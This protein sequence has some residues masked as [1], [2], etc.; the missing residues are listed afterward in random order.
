MSENNAGNNWKPKWQK[1]LDTYYPIYN[2]FIFTGYIDDLLPLEQDGQVVYVTME[3]YI[4]KQYGG[5]EPK[6]CVIVYDP[7]ESVEKQFRICAEQLAQPESD[8]EENADGEEEQ[9]VE[10]GYDDDRAQHF[11]DITHSDDIRDWLIDH[12]NDGP[13]LALS[14]MHYALTE[15]GPRISETER[16]RLPM[17]IKN[18]LLSLLGQQKAGGYI[19]V[20]KMAS[21]LLTRDTVSGNGNGISDEE[22]IIFRQL[23]N[24][25]Q[26]IQ[27]S[28]A[29]KIILLANKKE[30]LPVWFTD[31]IANHYLKIIDVE[32][33]SE[34]LRKYF[35]EEKLIGEG[36]FSDGFMQLYN[37]GTDDYRKRVKKKYVAYTDDFTMGMHVKFG[38]YAQTIKQNGGFAEFDDP[39]KIGFAVT[40]F[41]AGQM[42]N[43]WNDP[44]TVLKLI[45]IKE[46]I[47][48]DGIIG[49]SQALDQAQRI[50]TTAAVGLGR[51][52]SDAPRAVLFLVGPTGTGKTE[53][54]KKIAESVFGSKERM[55]RFD[56][57]EYREAESDQKLFGAP[58]GYVGY[59]N[60][61]R[62]TNA[63]K[64][65][66][67]SL[68]LF[69]E[70][71]KAHPSI[72][73]K[74]L[75]I[76][77]DGRLTDGKGETVRFTDCIIVVTSNCGITIDKEI[78]QE[79][80]ATQMGDEKKNF[81]PEFAEFADPEPVANAPRVYYHKIITIADIIAKEQDGVDRNI[82]YNNLK[83][84]LRF[85]VKAYFYCKLG[86]PELYGRFS[87]AMVY[88][89]FISME[90]VRPIVEK[91]IRET[92]KDAIT[93]KGLADIDFSAVLEK[94]ISCCNSKEVRASGARGINNKVDEVYGSGINDFFAE[95]LKRDAT[96]S[97]E[98]RTLKC[99]LSD[100]YASNDPITMKDIVWSIE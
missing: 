12:Q 3:E 39:E 43:P 62:L 30:D 94:L 24:I 95:E 71:E 47:E 28:D 50:L 81:T 23:L 97:F 77:G 46:S 67:F 15:N 93:V 54:C 98:G 69:D 63:I 2:T 96:Q 21:R 60:G 84:Q 92:N 17:R 53:L 55:V 1:D 88:Y 32:K 86:R 36:A 19:F 42:T 100:E 4:E 34:E 44:E 87:N 79:Q 59:E 56:M 22:L 61:G 38:E 99:R 49:Q 74:F 26:S 37:N 6:K 73:D 66:P 29:G 9:E 89:N 83:E 33:P 75:Q 25:A 16:Q 13:T 48:N 20:I 52:G 78:T 27:K 14:Y 10:I 76:I 40:T 11:Y 68:V 5:E 58:P 18:L 90:A 8:E 57:S 64:K 51:S 82:I 85:Y 45:T 65:E 91:K 31:E 70:I 80:L 35:F 72:L 7:T 41:R